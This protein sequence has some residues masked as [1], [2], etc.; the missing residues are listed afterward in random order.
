MPVHPEQLPNRSHT[1]RLGTVVAARQAFLDATTSKYVQVHTPY[2]LPTDDYRQVGNRQNDSVCAFTFHLLVPCVGASTTTNLKPR[3]STSMKWWWECSA[4]SSCFTPAV[5]TT[6]GQRTVD[7]GVT[8]AIAVH[9][10]S[11]SSRLTSTASFCITYKAYASL[12]S[13]DKI[14]NKYE[15]CNLKYSGDLIPCP[16]WQDLPSQTGS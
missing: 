2:V 6:L 1:T 5:V 13:M 10:C 12:L 14:L 16:I 7:H 4:S 9:C 11:W 8:I 3:W 15:L